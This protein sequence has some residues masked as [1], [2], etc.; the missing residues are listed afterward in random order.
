MASLSF[1]VPLG[2]SSAAAV[3]VGHL[4]GRRD[5]AAAGRAG[6][7]TVSLETRKIVNSLPA[8]KEQNEPAKAGA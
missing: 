8:L 2:I 5:P 4:I 3:R 1:M 7:I 6:V